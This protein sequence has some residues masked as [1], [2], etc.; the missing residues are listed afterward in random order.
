MTA[1]ASRH[2]LRSLRSQRS[3]KPRVALGSSAFHCPR[4]TPASRRSPNRG[5]RCS[6]FHATRGCIAVSQRTNRSPSTRRPLT[7]AGRA[8]EATP[9]GLLLGVT[10]HAVANSWPKPG[11]HRTGPTVESR[12]RS[13]KALAS[14]S[15]AHVTGRAHRGHGC[16]INLPKERDL[17]SESLSTRGAARGHTFALSKQS[18]ERHDASPQDGSIAGRA[19]DE[20]HPV[21]ETAAPPLRPKTSGQH[22]APVGGRHLP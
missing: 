20:T 1:A 17:A 5:S 6:T 4:S 18:A 19:D 15:L 14:T 3:G 11:A 8:A 7:P 9:P 16:Q 12:C 2:L 22:G 13:A 21:S 10:R